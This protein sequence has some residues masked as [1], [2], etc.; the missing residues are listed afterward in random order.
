MINT[1]SII[2]NF[3]LLEDMLS[4]TEIIRPLNYLY[5]KKKSQWI[6]LDLDK[7]NLYN[8]YVATNHAKKLI[9]NILRLP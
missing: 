2:R 5:R 1:Y 7:P 6:V 4:S 8:I 9:T 3:F